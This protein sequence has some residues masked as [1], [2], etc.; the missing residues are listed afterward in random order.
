MRKLALLASMTATLLMSIALPLT[1]ASAAGLS[2]GCS[3]SP[4]GGAVASGFCTTTTAANMYTIS[5]QVQGGSGTYTY[6]WTPPTGHG[7]I[8]IISG[9]TSTTFYCNLSARQGMQDS[10][11][12]ATVVLTQNGTRTTLQAEA[13]IPAVCPGQPHPV[14]C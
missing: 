2:L 3:I 12:V 11:D 10:D 7:I 5:Y 6:S 13:F 4:P 9:C 1:P 14:F 8:G